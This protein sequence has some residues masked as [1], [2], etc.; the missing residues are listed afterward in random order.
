MGKPAHNHLWLP[1]ILEISTCR[2]FSDKMFL[3]KY[4][5]RLGL[6]QNIFLRIFI[7]VKK[8]VEKWQITQG[9]PVLV[10]F[11]CIASSG[12]WLL[13]KCL[14]EKKNQETLKT[15]YSGNEGR[16]NGY[17][18]LLRENFCCSHTVLRCIQPPNGDL[19]TGAVAVVCAMFHSLPYL[20]I[21]MSSTLPAP[22][23]LHKRLLLLVCTANES[24]PFG[25]D[26][27][28]LCVACTAAESLWT[29]S[30]TC[31]AVV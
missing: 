13:V 14:T 26:I 12:R 4:F 21:R 2:K 3:F 30:A 7:H 18:A 1:V 20:W 28:C 16:H 23:G 5:C 17:Q 19:V 8:Y 6:P 9:V 29:Q 10:A 22:Q 24:V 15:E 11:K 31:I 27:N 25:F